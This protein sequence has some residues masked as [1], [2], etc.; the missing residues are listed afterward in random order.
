MY[1]LILVRLGSG[2]CEQGGYRY[3][4]V[5]AVTRDGYI[6]LCWSGSENGRGVEPEGRGGE[7]TLRN[8]HTRRYGCCTCD[9]REISTST[10]TLITLLVSAT[11]GN[12]SASEGR[13]SAS[14]RFNARADRHL[15]PAPS[16]AAEFTANP[17]D[18]IAPLPE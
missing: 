10:H 1:L 4:I 12:N 17:L 7:V 3:K 14:T 9:R 8:D 15:S 13:A 6:Q 16:T 5:A 18:I 11:I 2:L